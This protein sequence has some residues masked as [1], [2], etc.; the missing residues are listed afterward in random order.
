MERQDE[1]VLDPIES[2][3]I[4]FLKL[5]SKNY[6]HDIP[7]SFHCSQGNFMAFA[8][9]YS[10]SRLSDNQLLENSVSGIL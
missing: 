10:Y 7:C 3:L 4:V 2:S 8:C 6:L 9:K 1:G 5:S